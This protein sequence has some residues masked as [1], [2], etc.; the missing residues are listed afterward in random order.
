LRRVVNVLRT[1]NETTYDTIAMSDREN[2]HEQ[3]SNRQALARKTMAI[4][5]LGFLIDWLTV[6]LWWTI[7]AF[8]LSLILVTAARRRDRD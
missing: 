4:P 2:T 3:F 6:H 5:L 7:G 1:N 8:V